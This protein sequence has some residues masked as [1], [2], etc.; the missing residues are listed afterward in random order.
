MFDAVDSTANA[1]MTAVARTGAVR[2]GNEGDL[3]VAVKVMREELK[4]FLTEPKY[5]DERSLTL[6]GGQG[7]AM[8]SLVA[9]CTRRI[10]AERAA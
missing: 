7:L 1:L 6:T 10:L 3:D 5:A 4:A 2:Q 8:A 9:E